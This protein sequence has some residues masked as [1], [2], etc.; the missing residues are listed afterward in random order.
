MKFV[1]V[2]DVKLGMELYVAHPEFGISSY[3]V[4]SIPYIKPDFSI[5]NTLWV[6]LTWLDNGDKTY[7]SLDD[8]GIQSDN[9]FYKGCFTLEDANEYIESMKYNPLF[10][11]AM[12]KHMNA[13]SSWDYALNL[14]EY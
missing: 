13:I 11:E 1:K 12:M 9:F 5:S 3:I 2:E 4:H 6:D 7:I 8:A 10:L 14:Y